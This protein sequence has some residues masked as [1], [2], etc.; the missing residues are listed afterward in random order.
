MSLVG[1]RFGRWLVK[2]IGEPYYPPNSKYTRKRYN[3]VCDCG[4]VKVVE[5]SSLSGGK[6]KSCGCLLKETVTTHGYSAHPLYSVWQGMNH[7]CSDTTHKSYKN[8]GGRGIKVCDE[9]LG[10]PTGLLQ[11]MGDMGESYTNGL[12]LDRIDVNG[13]Y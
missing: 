1:K 5:G 4:T 9:W 13:N 3:C 6:S 11:F 7:R 2:G 8:Y 12:E 10:I